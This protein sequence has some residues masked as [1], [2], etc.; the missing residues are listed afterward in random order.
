M[1]FPPLG[2]RYSQ[3]DG[4]QAGA[5]DADAVLGAIADDLMEHGDLGWAL[6]NLLARGL[7][8]A[9]G[10]HSQGL[11]QL[12]QRLREQ[13]RERLD[14]FD[15]S[16]VM[17][18]IERQ[19]NDILKREQ[20]T[21]D[22]WA[23]RG[24]DAF[25]D[26]MLRKIAERNQAELDALPEDTA[27]R[28]KALERYEFLN[29]DAQR[30]FIA[31]LNQLRKAMTQTFFKDVENMVQRLSDGDIARMKEMLNALHD[32]LVKKI[33]GEEPDFEGFMARFGDMFGD[34]PPA[35]LEALLEQM[36]QQ[37]VAAQSMLGSMS[38]DQ[39]AQLL[40]MMA[41]RFADP[42]LDQ[43]LRQL[44]KAMDFLNPRGP[45]YRF[46]GSDELDLEAAMRL[47]QEMHRLDETMEQVQAA[48]RYG[49]L[50]RI[51]R[52]AIAELL[53][54]EDAEGLDNLKE[55]LDA[56]KEAGYL[57]EAGDKWELTPRGSR[58]IGQH[59]L[60]EIYARLKRQNLGNH[61]LPEAG[62]FGERMAETKPYEHGD[63]FHLNMPRTIRNAMD[64]EGPALPIKLRADDFEVDRSE[65]LTST[66]TA[67]LVD[68]SWSMALRGS[69]EAAKKVALALHHLITSQY[70]RDSFHI[71]GFAAY[72]NELKPRDLPFLQWDEYVLGTNMQ[73]ALLLAEQLL[74][75]DGAGTKQIILISDGEPTAHLLPN[76]R[77]QF[78]YPPTL[79][80]WRATFRAVRR[81][82]RK[83]IAINTFML[84]ANDHLKQFMEQM[85]RINGGRVFYSTPERLGEY[86]LVDYV[87]NKRKRLGGGR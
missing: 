27:G 47:M 30:D 18:D 83:G 52:D 25:S 50:D 9:D 49:D 74:C 80:T 48:A 82:T 36:R 46:G 10:G 24:E 57:R 8:N 62:R 76:G 54:D 7:P 3:W 84:D 78:A 79:E 15:L 45:R 23:A 42:E 60:G 66:A 87:D 5:V 17:Q 21:L 61:P 43:A 13:K 58:M 35:T 86:I 65:R 32:M 33:A 1:R 40:S 14:R 56:L 67:M 72:A 64:R 59:A 39:R 34:N 70:P 31:L 19:L 51:D 20:A 4:T 73:H 11:R 55:L 16:T 28:I 12:L 69:F 53:G 44:T 41:D 77:H 63:A 22:E 6:R 29:P 81:C 71:I 85:A 2:A 37:M 26:E 38:P 68:Q 75:R